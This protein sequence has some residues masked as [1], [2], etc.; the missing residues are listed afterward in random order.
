LKIEIA[1]SPDEALR[2]AILAPLVAFNE[3]LAGPSGHLPLALAL[4]DEKG[5]TCGG[6]WGSTAYGWL[7]TQMLVVPEAA[8]G[9]GFGR[10]LMR[11][12]EAEAL[13]RGCAHAWVDTQFGGRG[14]YE[15]LGYTVFGEL[16][17]YPPGF[18]RTFLRK[19]LR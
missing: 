1:D 9:Q 13:R 16:A 8:R 14:F 19:S 6:L 11:A 4:R 17:D 5:E 12:A 10:E 15:R 3:A 7:Y 18:R 2:R